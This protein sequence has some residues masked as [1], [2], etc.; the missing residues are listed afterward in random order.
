[1][2]K[3]FVLTSLFVL[4]LGLSLG[5]VALAEERLKLYQ[6]NEVQ[7]QHQRLVGN[8]RAQARR[9]GVVVNVPQLYVFLSD[10]SSAYHMD[11]YRPG[12]ERELNLIVDRSRTAR[13]MV[14]LDRLLE[15]VKAA[16]GSAFS[17]ADLPPADVYIAL[18]RRADCPTCDRVAEA[19]AAW[20][21]S[22]PGL[23][24]VW[25]DVS[26]DMPPRQH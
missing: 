24:V 1:M 23:T 21:E 14:R 2:R 12:F 10:Q 16:D 25:L 6:K 3:I 5:P 9:E 13:S 19:L 15:R 26:L 11:G 20:R 18:Y 8:V 4:Y 17:P 7:V 22:R